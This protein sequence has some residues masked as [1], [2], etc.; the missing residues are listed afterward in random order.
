MKF[1][2]SN[3][4][5]GLT[6]IELLVVFA[7]IAT[8]VAALLP[9]VS[10]AREAARRSRCAAN[11]RQIGLAMHG[12]ASDEG[13]AV[14]RFQFR[15]SGAEPNQFP[16]LYSTVDWYFVAYGYM[17]PSSPAMTLKEKRNIFNLATQVNAFDCPTT[18]NDVGFFTNGWLQGTGVRKKIFDYVYNTR[19]GNAPLGITEKRLEEIPRDKIV[20]IDHNQAGPWYSNTGTSYDGTSTPI[21]GPPGTNPE[22]WNMF[23]M[24]GGPGGYSPGVHHN[25]GANILYPDGHVARA[26]AEKYLPNYSLGVYNPIIDLV[27]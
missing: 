16:P 25:E 22:Y 7:I 8:M 2:R 4:P 3:A 12:Y 26:K 6:M 17:L 10:N 15:W 1:K 20:I 27:P 14:A 11:Q 13:G 9:A 5:R 18:G 24:V 21:T 23:M 19:D